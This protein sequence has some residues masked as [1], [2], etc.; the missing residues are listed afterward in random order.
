MQSFIL[1]TGNPGKLEEMQTYFTGLDLELLL[2]PPELEIEET[3]ETFVDNAC[4]KASEVAKATGEWAIAD[5]SGLAIDALGG[6][7]GIYSARYGNSDRDRIERVLRE[8]DGSPNRRAKFVCAIALASPSGEIVIT[9]EGICPGEII[10]A[11]R[12]TG[13]FGY[14]PIFYL[15]QHQLTF[16]ELTPEMKHQVSHRGEAFKLFLPKFRALFFNQ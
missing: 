1:A 13:G 6:A 4:L 12:G 8:L 14:D 11:P 5:D 2:K 7:P 10:Q 16:A 15:P 9:T 3:G